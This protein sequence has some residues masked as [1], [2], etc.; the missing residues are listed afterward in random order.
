MQNTREYK[1]PVEVGVR[2]CWAAINLIWALKL[3]REGTKVEKADGG[4][5]LEL[6]NEQIG[7]L[8][9]LDSLFLVA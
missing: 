3:R 5:L 1:H 2:L 9:F 6:L 8:L 4:T 7:Q